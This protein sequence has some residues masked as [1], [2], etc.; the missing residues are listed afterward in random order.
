MFFDKF[1]ELFMIKRS[2]YKF[3]EQKFGQK[4]K[5]T[6][7]GGE[8]VGGR[9]RILPSATLDVNNFFILKQT[10]PNLVTFF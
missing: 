8:G 1:A 4:S 7:T 2:F 5:P 6:Q 3:F 10:L 9:G